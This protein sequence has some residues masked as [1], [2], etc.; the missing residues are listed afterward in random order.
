MREADGSRQTLAVLEDG[1]RCCITAGQEAVWTANQAHAVDVAT[2][3]VY[4]VVPMLPAHVELD[5]FGVRQ[6]DLGH[7]V[8]VRHAAAAGHDAT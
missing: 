1:C 7:D 6:Y 8:A 5:A 4:G 3:A 2:T